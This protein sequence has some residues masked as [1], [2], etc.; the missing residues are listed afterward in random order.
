MSGEIRGNGLRLP[1]VR[2]WYTNKDNEP[3]ITHTILSIVAP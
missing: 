2:R 3:V 1:R